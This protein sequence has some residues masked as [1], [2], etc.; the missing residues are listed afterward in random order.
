[1]CA[2]T[3]KVEQVGVLRIPSKKFFEQLV[4]KHKN[5][6]FKI[7]DPKQLATYIRIPDMY[8]ITAKFESLLPDSFNNYIYQYYI[9]SPI[10]TKITGTDLHPDSAY[11]TVSTNIVKNIKTLWDNPDAIIGSK[12]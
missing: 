6:S 10:P 4:E 11:E 1:M 2:A 8:R 5:N 7:T 12:K 9:N 3:F